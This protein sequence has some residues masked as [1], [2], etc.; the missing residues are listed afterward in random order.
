ME[1]KRGLSKKQRD[2]IVERD[3]GKSQMRHYSEEEGWHTGGYC[4]D[5]ENP[6]PHLHVHH[7]EPHGAGGSDDPTNL[8]TVSECE[9]NGRC[10]SG[11]IKK[12]LSR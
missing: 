3:E 9:H 4:K 5:P 12:G 7:I 6:C 11:R 1:R 10:P 2:S 8:I